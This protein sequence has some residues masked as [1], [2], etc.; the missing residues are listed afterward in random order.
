MMAFATGMERVGKIPEE[1]GQMCKMDGVEKGMRPS[2]DIWIGYR[3][4]EEKR[5]IV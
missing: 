3:E 1:V 5:A 2:D 4:E